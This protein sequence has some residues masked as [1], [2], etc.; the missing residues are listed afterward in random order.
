M[1]PTIQLQLSASGE[2]EVTNTDWLAS[3]AAL[4]LAGLR[5]RAKTRTW[6]AKPNWVTARRLRAL[7]G[8]NLTVSDRVQEWAA[9]SFAT[10]I[11]PA[12]NAKAGILTRDYPDG[13]YPYQKVGAELL[14][15]AKGAVL[16]DAPRVGKCGSVIAAIK[17]G[18]IKRTLWI[19]PRTTL[20][21]VQRMFELLAPDLTVGVA[22]G[23][24][25]QRRKVIA[26]DPDVLLI[27]YQSALSHSRQ[28]PYGSVR[29]K[30]C[31]DC[32][33]LGGDDEYTVSDVKCWVHKK[34][35]NLNHYDAVVVDECHRVKDPKAQQTR[36][37]WALADD[38]EYKWGLSGTPIANDIGEYW[39]VLRM[40]D[41]VSWPTRGGYLDNYVEVVQTPWGGSEIVGLKLATRDEFFDLVDW[42]ILR[43]TYEEIHGEADVPEP[44]LR[45]VE[46][47][48]A[49][50]KLYKEL[51]DHWMTSAGQ[52]GF[53][54]TP[55]ELSTRLHQMASGYVEV[56]SDQ[57]SIMS[58]DWKLA[59]LSHV[60]EELGDEPAVIFTRFI[61]L[62][63][64]TAS[65]MGMAFPGQV[66]WLRSEQTDAERKVTLDK[67]Q[68][69]DARYIISTYS[70][71]SEGVDLSRADTIIRMQRPWDMVQDEQASLRTMNPEKGNRRPLLVDIVTEDTIDMDVIN[72]LDRKTTNLEE[73]VRDRERKAA[74]V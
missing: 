30:R 46:M 38:A 49:A 6:N 23:N 63:Y 60:L 41:P 44:W 59:E 32:G 36:A 33:G 64:L 54:T 37:V 26:S 53:V 24:I 62:A 68:S 66:A 48:T 34:E 29:M 16:Q 50:R 22:V 73:L 11:Q 51:E 2:F 31:V 1:Q 25:T 57:W 9:N 42:R 65:F 10:S 55:M 69:G 12:L 52:G 19:G 14:L 28:A 74:V 15:N 47:P 8:E 58:A 43:R 5:Y 17:G 45:T 18:G 35:L 20:I 71:A 67:F 4:R 13:A 39:S 7:F 3:T 40:I 61:D 70:L 27:S 72:A 56:H 21:G